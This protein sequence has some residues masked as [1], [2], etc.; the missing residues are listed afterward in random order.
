ME[1]D[2]RTARLASTKH[3]VYLIF[4]PFLLSTAALDLGRDSEML[5]NVAA[6]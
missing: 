3:F 1:R 5:I 2:V 6:S 4:V